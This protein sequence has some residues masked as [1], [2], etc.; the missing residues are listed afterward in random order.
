MDR[1]VFIVG[2][3]L[4]QT[5][6]SNAQNPLEF[7]KWSGDIVVPDPVAVSVDYRGRVYVTQTQRRKVQDLDIRR[8]QDWI[9]DDVGL[10]SIESKRKFYRDRLAPDS[11]FENTERV[12]DLNRDGSHDWRDLT[13]L[14]ER[15]HLL[16]DTDSNGI[17]DRTGVFAEDFQTE[18]TGIAAGVLWHDD[19]VYATIAPDVWKLRDTDDDG[20]A[21]SR[22][23]VATGFGFHI[24]YAGHDMHGLT[25]GPDGKIYWSIGDKGIPEYP[26]EGG[27]M[28]CNPDGS[29]FEV[30]AHGLR[31]VQELAFDEYG[32]LFGVDND[33]DNTSEKERFV[34]IVRGMDAGWRCHYQYRGKDYN[35][36]MEE[37]IWQP[38]H[39][40]ED[41]HLNRPLYAVPPI[42][43]YKDGPCGFVYNPGTALGPG[44]ERTFFMTEAPKGVQW[45]F[46]VKQE[47]ASFSMVNSR[48]IA[49]GKALIGW[50]FGPDGALY[51]ADWA[52]G[53]PLNQQGAIWR[54]DVTNPDPRRLETQSILETDFTS[55]SE[56]QLALYLRHPD[57]RVRLRAQFRLVER[58]ANQVF[59]DVVDGNHELARIHSL[60]GLGQLGR[61]APLIRM[62]DDPRPEIC[63]Q[64]LKVLGDTPAGSL[65]SSSLIPLLSHS[66]RRVRFHAA[67]ALARHPAPGAFEKLVRGIEKEN[68]HPDT[69]YLIHAAFLA[70]ASSSD[71]EKLGTLSRHDSAL[72]RT[73]AVLALRHQRSPRV[74][75][76]LR[77]TNIHTAS[78]AARAIHDDLGI[79]EALPALAETL[80]S[81]PFAD[82]A[83]LRRAVNA[84]LI[85]GT[86]EHAARVLQFARDQKSP[87]AMRRH[88][89]ETL[90]H[91]TKPPVLDRVTG[92][93]R[94]PKPRY[95]GP[96]AASLG[97]AG[98]RDLLA[99]EDP[100]VIEK[101]LELTSNLGIALESDT[102]M[103]VMQNQKAPE[104]VRVAA[105]AN[106]LSSSSND[107]QGE[108]PALDYALNSSSRDLRLHALR[109]LVGSN[110]PRAI[111]ICERILDESESLAERQAALEV[112]A[113]SK[114]DESLKRW[115]AK[116]Q[117]GHVEKGLILDIL[118]AAGSRGIPV[119]WPRD[120]QDPLSSW[121]ECLTGGD[122]DRGRDIF[123]NHIAAQCIRCH[124]VKDGKGSGIGP[125]L[126]NA[127]LNDRTYLLQSLVKPNAAIPEGFGMISVTTKDGGE[128]AGQL[129]RI[130]KTHIHLRSAEGKSHERIRRSEIASQTK[131]MSLMPPMGL[132][133]SNRELR[134]VIEYLATLRDE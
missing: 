23:S 46:Q 43:H 83:Y 39:P 60:W 58:G 127:G 82:E 62:L 95:P 8:N 61:L 126:K 13:V 36:W 98:L 57:Q 15:I 51:A 11:S 122:A 101:T 24:A 64:A 7:T 66:H 44:W 41:G 113:K 106:L 37:N 111:R 31:N 9:P 129:H 119:A 42:C 48:R 85:L 53:Y 102:L 89:L 5:A 99:D 49:A 107:S 12:A 79:P 78:E 94:I 115:I 16:E 1:C 47:G 109:T 100:L 103:A 105:L 96:V 110:R 108:N 76:F 92:Q 38:G 30:F 69:P 55:T 18:V 112:L 86:P 87:P 117:S 25:V 3:A 134:D 34:Y 97:K 28:R 93:K 88:A 50:N 26:N 81:P 116:L 54:I 90:A 125:N 75:V 124:K 72:V 63:V 91:W 33:S 65:D 71:G 17:A 130:T 27:V 21:D 131:P 74:A 14:S 84:N 128:F 133:L 118:E 20:V 45:A 56:K 52:G 19:A 59:E 70:L 35:P 32:N 77:D 10:A 121:K 29:D 22:E 80:P 104:S 40:A 2:L 4:F 6:V 73:T 123:T 120:P 114:A 68:L 132:I 67:L